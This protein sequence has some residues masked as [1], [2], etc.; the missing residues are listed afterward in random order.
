[1]TIEIHKV[2]N[3]FVIRT[4]VNNTYGYSGQI[5][6]YP[7]IGPQNKEYVADS[8]DLAISKIRELLSK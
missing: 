1:M 4:S 3:G 2:E 8:L 6:G 5:G 7:Q